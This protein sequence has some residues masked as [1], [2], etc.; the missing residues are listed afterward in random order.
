MKRPSFFYGYNIAAA[1]FFI[2]AIGIGTHVAF[3]VFFKPLLADFGWSRATLSGASSLAM[4]IA[5]FLGIL[6]GRLNDRFGPRLMMT[7]TGFLFGL[8]LLLMQGLDNIWQLYLFYGVVV[9]IGL[10]SIDIIALSTTARWFV[11]RRGMMTGIVKVGTG[12]GQL[13]MP[14]MSSMLIIAYGWRTSY[15]IIGALVMVLLIAAGQV[16]RRD[17]ARLGLLPDG[18]RESLTASPRPAETGFY[19]HEALR[20]RQFWTICLAFLTTMFCLLII[21]VHI[22][23]HATDIGVPA[24]TAAGILSAIGGISMA[25][26]FVTG[27]AID[28]IGNKRSMIICLILLILA[29]L[30]LQLARELWMLYL[31]AV[32][33]GF[34]HGGLLTVISPIVAEYFGV[35]SH[36]ALFGIVFFSTM[37]GGAAGPVFAGFIFDT[38]GTYTAAFWTCAA[39]A[40]TA[41]ALIISLTQIRPSGKETE[42]E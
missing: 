16:L 1:C 20:T 30:W 41:L 13:V 17:P 10:S 4:L 7:V 19:L 39:L 15:L 23:P 14:L 3:G 38:T 5:G 32:I 34:G 35:R 18:D 26:R 28:R 2:Q 6:V 40:A 29:L 36:G 12:A 24:T 22:V 37:V 11:R 9:G 42:R 8:G 33:Y 31:F 27:F 25:G 21:L